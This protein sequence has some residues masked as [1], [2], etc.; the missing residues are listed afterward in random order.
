MNTGSELTDKTNIPNPQRQARHRDLCLRGFGRDLCHADRPGG[1]GGHPA[2]DPIR[3]G[4]TF[5]GWDKAIPA[6]MPAENITITARWKDIEK[7]TG[8]IIIGTDKAGIL[9]Q[10]SPPACSLRIRRRYDKR[11]R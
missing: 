2:D 11:R 6:T 1:R 8:E 9:K 4:Y 3:G 5:I 7:P 10:S